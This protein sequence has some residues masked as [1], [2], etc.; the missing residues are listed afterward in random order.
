MAFLIIVFY[1]I[2]VSFGGLTFPK[3]NLIQVV[4][5]FAIVL[6][7][8]IQFLILGLLASGLFPD[9]RIDHDGISFKYL[10]FVKGKIQWE[11]IYDIKKFSTPTEYMAVFIKREGKSFRNFFGLWIQFIY[12]RAFNSDLPVILITD[13][14]IYESIE[15]SIRLS[16]KT[17]NDAMKNCGFCL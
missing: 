17:I 5:S 12:G 9:I 8:P 1:I 2:I 13:R 10:E 16:K 7:F 11:E 15:K 4:V 14:N 3:G 6:I